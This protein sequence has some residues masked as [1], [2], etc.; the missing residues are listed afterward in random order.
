MTL[1]LLLEVP[2]VLPLV[3]LMSRMLLLLYLAGALQHQL[4]TRETA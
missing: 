4:N 1:P 3:G 2:R